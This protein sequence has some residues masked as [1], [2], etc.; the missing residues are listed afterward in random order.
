MSFAVAGSLRTKNRLEQLGSPI[1]ERKQRMASLILKMSVSLDG[2][3]A[4]ADGSS[5]WEAAGRSPDGAEWV[6]DTVSNAG[7]HLMGAATHAAMAAHWPTD[8]SPFAKPM[9]EIPKVV[10]SD[11]LAS[12]DW[13][14]TTIVRG[15][16]AEA[17][18]RLK[19]EHSGGYLLA[20]G[21]ARFARSLVETGLIDEY[22]LVVHPVIL[23]AGERLFT[24][25]LTM[26]PVSTIAFSGGAVAH[27]FTAHP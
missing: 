22:R 16:L 9:N 21:G 24:T 11:S 25:P 4:P 7:A 2:Y 23:G 8:S 18:T 6:L 15:D 20:H 26:E 10:F 19:K 17:I 27:V 5:G 3:V 12:A 14:E 1:P 13:D